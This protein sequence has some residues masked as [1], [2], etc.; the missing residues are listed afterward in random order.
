MQEYWNGVHEVV[1][2]RQIAGYQIPENI[3]INRN[4]QKLSVTPEDFFNYLYR[5]DENG[6]SAYNRDLAAQSRESRRDDEILRAYLMFVGGNYSNLVN[7]AI[8]KEKVATL[9][10]RAKE[11]NTTTVRINKPKPNNNST[12]IDLG[13]N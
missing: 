5:V 4:G 11:R 3:I 1:K 7:M 8:N 12:N 9:K 6:M 13:Y 2:S 10:L